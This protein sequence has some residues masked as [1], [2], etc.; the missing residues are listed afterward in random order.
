MR[1]RSRRTG[2]R[3][4]AR[5]EV[6]LDP[7]LEYETL[8]EVADLDNLLGFKGN[9]MM[10]PL[11]K[12]N[13]LTDFM[14][15]PYIDPVRPPRPG[16]PR[17]LDARGVRRVR[18][19]PARRRSKGRFDSCGRGWRRSTASQR[20]GSRRRGDRRADGLAVHRG[21]AGRAPDP[22]RLQT[23]PS[24]DGR[25]EGAGRGARAEL[26]NIRA[27]ARLLAG[28]REDPSIEKKILIEGATE[29]IVPP[30]A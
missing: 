17:Q 6:E 29:V 21:A 15:I 3:L 2:S 28:E 12:G 18:L 7:G 20:A 16:P 9:Y 27:A 1:S 10:F 26:E 5:G 14:M 19:L 30:E 22:G 13:D 8:E 23:A 4:K 24:R 25:E 11:K